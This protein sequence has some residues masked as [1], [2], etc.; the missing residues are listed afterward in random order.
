[1][2]LEIGVPSEELLEQATALL[3]RSQ[4]LLATVDQAINSF[5]PKNVNKQQRK[6]SYPATPRIDGLHKLRSLVKA[7]AKFLEKL[8]LHPDTIRG[9]HTSCSNIPYLSAVLQLAQT[10]PEVTQVFQTFHYAVDDHGGLSSRQ[11][12]RVDVVAQNGRQWIKVKASSLKGFQQELADDESSDSESEDLSGHGFENKLTGS[13]ATPKLPIYQQAQ[14]LLMAASQNQVHFRVPE[15]VMTFLGL[16][17]VDPRIIETLRA[18]GVIVDLR[19]GEGSDGSDS[20]TQLPAINKSIPPVI[21]D[22]GANCNI[23]DTLN[24]DVTTLISLVTDIAHRPD[25]IPLEALDGRRVVTTETAARK[26]LDIVNLL[27]GPTE[28]KRAQ[29]LLV[30]SWDQNDRWKQPPAAALTASEEQP[31]ILSSIGSLRVEVI[32]DN[33]SERFL[34]MASKT[35]SGRLKQHH[36][37]VFGTG[38]RER[39]TTVTANAW[40]DRSLTD[41]GLGGLSLWIHEPRSLVEQR[42]AVYRAETGVKELVNKNI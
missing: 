40:I 6:N 30:S 27:G 42:V 15:I 39:I 14:D 29:R 12:V 20:T 25:T 31:S 11:A 10:Q 34:N 18:M 38:D 5:A 8:V 9:S 36:I 35:P 13:L 3:N 41:A 2:Q 33:P 32:A 26:M 23:T 21:T 28:L 24:L 22:D 7:E 1:M 19:T 16:E 37:A 17:E 4:S